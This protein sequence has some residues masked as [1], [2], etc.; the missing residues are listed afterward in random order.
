MD[1]D[2]DDFPEPA[3]DNPANDKWAQ[4]LRW[5]GLLCGLA[6]LGWTAVLLG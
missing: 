4:A 2:D 3:R 5:L 6:M 1:E